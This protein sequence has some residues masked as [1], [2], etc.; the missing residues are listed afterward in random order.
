[1][2]LRQKIVAVGIALFVLLFIINLV[3][4]RKLKEEYSWLWIVTGITLLSVALWYDLLVFMTRLIGAG[5]PTS[6]LF[7]FGLIFLVLISLHFSIKLSD[8]STKIKNLAQKVA[9]LENQLL[10]E[11]PGKT[12]KHEEMPL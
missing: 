5:L 6:T 12:I 1:M 9:I 2:P 11:C 10:G 8:Q 3:R 7:F 4:T